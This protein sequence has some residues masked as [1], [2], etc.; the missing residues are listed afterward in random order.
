M[1]TII[2]IYILITCFI[3]NFPL[4]AQNPEWVIIDTSNSELSDNSINSMAMDKN[5][6]IIIQC[7]GKYGEVFKINKSDWLISR[8]SNI[9]FPIKIDEDGF[10]WYVRMYNLIKGIDD[11]TIEFFTPP[12]SLKWYYGDLPRSID[13]DNDG[14]IWML[15]S[16]ELYRFDGVNWSILNKN[17]MAF[18]D[19]LYPEFGSMVIDELNKIWIGTERHG[20]VRYDGTSWAIY[21][22]SNSNLPGQAAHALAMD[23]NGFLWLLSSDLL[24]NRHLVKIDGESWTLIKIPLSRISV[25]FPFNIF[26]SA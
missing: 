15:F 19:T 10:S 16:Y 23:D 6:D 2:G 21:D 4:L 1:K 20:L 26:M 5:G 22:T 18:P 24:S 9:N 14:T 25:I 12:D 8:C 17:D 3:L 7:G 13:I 11:N